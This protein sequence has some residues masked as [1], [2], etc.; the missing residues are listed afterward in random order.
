MTSRYLCLLIP[1]LSLLIG[2]LFNSILPP[3]PPVLDCYDIKSKQTCYVLQIGQC[4]AHMVGHLVVSAQRPFCCRILITFM[5]H[6]SPFCAISHTCF[7]TTALSCAS[8]PLQ[9]LCILPAYSLCC[10]LQLRYSYS[11]PFRFS[12]TC[13]RISYTGVCLYSETP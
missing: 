13:R 11:V 9:I 12:L 8:S 5:I 2:L 3:R 4:P 7:F 10:V 1:Y 6:G